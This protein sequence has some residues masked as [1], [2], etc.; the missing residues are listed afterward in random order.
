VRTNRQGGHFPELQLLIDALK[1]KVLDPDVEVRIICRDLMDE[2]KVD[3]LTAQQFPREIFRFQ[4]GCHNKTIIVDKKVA[5]VGSHNWSNE[6]VAANR[7]A[8]L[9]FHD[10]EIA[11]YLA[12]I[13]DDGWNV[14][15]N[16]KPAKK[17]P[18]VARPDEP[19]PPGFVRVPFSAV[20]DD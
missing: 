7:D 18:R 4:P 12:E 13:Y 11:E 19:T 5:M 8:S 16:A 14:R 20:F 9:I 3:L 10:Q 6:G 17:K 1:Q 15:A 2:S